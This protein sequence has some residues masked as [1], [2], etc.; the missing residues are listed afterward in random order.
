MNWDDFLPHVLPSVVGCPESLAISHVI[1]AAR[2]FCEGT[3]ALQVELDLDTVAGQAVYE[4]ALPADQERSRILNVNVDGK[5]YA[6]ANQ[7]TG[8]RLAR[9]SRGRV[10]TPLS[11]T[12]MS[13]NP[14]PA[15]NDDPILVEIATK[16]K[17]SA[18]ACPDALGEFMTDIAAGA[19]ATLCALPKQDWT[20]LGTAALQQT[21]FT[22]RIAVVGLQVSKGRGR[23]RQ[24]S[25]ITMY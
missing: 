23:S 12:S 25:S 2:T 14:V 20:D 21:V 22:D 5:D 17:V 3:H 7:T 19:I 10:A 24:T 9:D 15:F 4:I 13:L 8:R 1:N 18:E 16:P 11:A 6:V